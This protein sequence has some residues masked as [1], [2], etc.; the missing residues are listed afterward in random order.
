MPHTHNSWGGK[1]I[2]GKEKLC[3][4]KLRQNNNTSNQYKFL[5]MALYHQITTNQKLETVH[6]HYYFTILD[7]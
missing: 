1:H 4:K 2:M 6:N 5:V 7:K 3:M